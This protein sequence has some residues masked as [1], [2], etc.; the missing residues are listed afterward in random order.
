MFYL[1]LEGYDLHVCWLN[2]CTLIMKIIVLFDASSLQ[3]ILW[4]AK[5]LYLYYLKVKI[6]ELLV[7]V[8]IYP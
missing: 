2:W 5:Y 1:I 3:Y 8:V 7:V 6:F 4:S